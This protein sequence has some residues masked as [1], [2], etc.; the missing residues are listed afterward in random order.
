MEYNKK[1]E[2]FSNLVKIEK[3]TILEDKIVPGSLV[4]ESPD[5]FPGYYDDAPDNSSPVYLYLA[6]DKPY[7]M[8]E[9]LRAIEHIQPQFEER[10]DAGKGILT[11]LNEDIPV[12]RLRHFG[13]Y[14][15]VEPLQTAFEKEGIIALK[16]TKKQG[17]YEA[18]IRI[19]KMLY[20]KQVEPNVYIDLREDYHGYIIIPRY[21]DW[22]QF[23]KITRQVK[24]NWFGSKFDAAYGSFYY[25]G[26]LH[27]FVR[28]YSDQLDIDYLQDIRSIYL[29]KLS[30]P[31]S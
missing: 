26:R 18:F 13:D 8:E 12:I 14:N 5:P 21:L 10:F 6:L 19:V 7:R 22:K 17:Q 2:V 16:A 24:Y 11:L 27:E 31:L 4:F 15:L 30:H 20:L 23:E 1:M 25:N 29:E 28:I 3:L 9:V